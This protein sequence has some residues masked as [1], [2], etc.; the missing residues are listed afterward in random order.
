MATVYANFI[1]VEPQLLGFSVNRTMDVTVL[2]GYLKV[3]IFKNAILR[4]FIRMQFQR[5]GLSDLWTTPGPKGF[6]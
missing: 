4:L 1:I 2:L 3:L 5:Y 6:G